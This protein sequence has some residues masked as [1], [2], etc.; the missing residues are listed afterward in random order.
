MARKGQS[1]AADG[2]ERVIFEH[3]DDGTWSA[4]PVANRGLVVTGGSMAQARKR[5]REALARGRSRKTPL[6][7]R[8]EV[9]LP[10][11]GTDAVLRL[12]AAREALE[13]AERDAVTVLVRRLGLG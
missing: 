8:E 10:K 13:A 6:V 9:R 3:H 5:M 1:G 4:W 12:Q 7:L 11:D 2:G